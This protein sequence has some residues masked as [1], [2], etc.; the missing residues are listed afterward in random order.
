MNDFKKFL[1]IFSQLALIFGI[2]IL[3]IWITS[4]FGENNTTEDIAKEVAKEIV[5]KKPSCPN[6]REAYRNLKDSEQSIILIENLNTFGEEGSFVNSKIVIVNSSGVGSEVAC[7][8]LFIEVEGEN[9]RPLQTEW[10]NPFVKPGQ[11]G[12]HLVTENS[13]IPR[14][15]NESN[16]F[17]FNLAKMQYR[18][19]RVSEEIRTADWAAL[20]NVS[21]HI[22]FEIALNTID[23][24]AII[25]EVSIVYQCWSP[26][27]GEI[28]KD[29][30][31]SVK[32]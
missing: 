10:E 16:Q 20:L 18:I 1:K 14:I 9:G 22:E 32:K 3:A 13:I 15:D 24:E 11:F 30:N 4:F 31:L 28:T 29:C 21:D 7:G 12:G 27:T 6:T 2:G 8:Y 5:A 26:E 19:S 25:K 17:L 23:S